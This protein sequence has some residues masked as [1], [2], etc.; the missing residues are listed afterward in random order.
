MVFVTASYQ[1]GL[2]TR[3]MTRRSIIVGVERRG[4]RARVETM[5]YMDPNMGPDMDV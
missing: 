4:G 5:L 3:S 2:D 1:T